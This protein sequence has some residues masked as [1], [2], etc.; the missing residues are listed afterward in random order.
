MYQIVPKKYDNPHSGVEL[1]DTLISTLDSN[2]RVYAFKL[3][4]NA[5]DAPGKT[6]YVSAADFYSAENLGD[7]LVFIPDWMADFLDVEFGAQAQVEP[8]EDVPT[9]TF[10]K[11]NPPQ[12]LFDLVPDLGE[13][14]TNYFENFQILQTGISYPIPLGGEFT[15]EEIKCGG[16]SVDYA[17]CVDTDLEVDFATQTGPLGVDLAEQNGPPGVDPPQ[18]T[19]MVLPEP[20][21]MTPPPEQIIYIPPTSEK[22]EAFTGTGYRLG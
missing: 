8:I 9:A 6:L 21:P 11:I 14:F 20:L 5:S 3:T 10:I 4:L 1:P 7:E 17:L 18:A 2:G 16:V 13:F 15:I 19:G 22:F 12:H